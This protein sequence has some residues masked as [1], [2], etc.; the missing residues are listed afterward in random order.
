MVANHAVFGGWSIV[1]ENEGI[2][3]KVNRVGDGLDVGRLVIPIDAE[4]NDVVVA[5][6]S[7]AIASSFFDE[8]HRM[9]PGSFPVSFRDS[10]IRSSAE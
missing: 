3:T 10:A 9:I 5:Y 4:R 8:T 1:E 7:S 2:E 6:A